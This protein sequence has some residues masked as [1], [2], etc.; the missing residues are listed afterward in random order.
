MFKS[1]AKQVLKTLNSQSLA[2]CS[3]ESG[4]CVFHYLI[5]DDVIFLTLTERSYPKRLAFLYLGEV[6]EG[7]VGELERDYGNVWREKVRCVWGGRCEEGG[8]ERR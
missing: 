8:Q 6:H 2:K 4:D 7:F 1:Q 3:I 5:L